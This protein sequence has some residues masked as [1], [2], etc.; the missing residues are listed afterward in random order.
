MKE[1]YLLLP[2]R[3]SNSKYEYALLMQRFSSIILHFVHFVHFVFHL[4]FFFLG[5]RLQEEKKI[6][7]TND[8][9][10]R[11]SV[12]FSLFILMYLLR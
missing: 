3:H 6:L 7:S 5:K 2:F 8:M 9:Q 12:L 1:F 4:P 11:G 10:G